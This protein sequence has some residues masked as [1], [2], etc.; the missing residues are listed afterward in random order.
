MNI[1]A[2]AIK[3]LRDKTG[4]PMLDCKNALV[5]SNGDEEKAM[6]ILRLNSPKTR[7]VVESIQHMYPE[8]D[9]DVCVRNDSIV[10][11]DKKTQRVFAALENGNINLYPNEQ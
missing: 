10:F 8:V 9:F 7:L 1:S 3:A 6:V 5:E 11:L 4:L 2:T